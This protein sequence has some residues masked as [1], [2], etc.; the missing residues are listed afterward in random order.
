MFCRAS[1][2]PYVT[3]RNGSAT[4]YVYEQTYLTTRKNVRRDGT[5]PCRAGT[6]NVSSPLRS[7][8]Y[9][10]VFDTEHTH[11]HTQTLVFVLY[12]RLSNDDIQSVSEHK[13]IRKGIYWVGN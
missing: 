11:T 1:A 13:A 10:I 9:L 8:Y 4:L 2:V 3:R 5:E 7:I 12:A 6:D